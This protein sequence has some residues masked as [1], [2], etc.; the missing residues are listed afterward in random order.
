[1]LF[2]LSVVMVMLR[3]DRSGEANFACCIW[4]SL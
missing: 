2:A 3:N 1:V 4:E